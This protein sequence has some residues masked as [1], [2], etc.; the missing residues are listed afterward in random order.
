MKTYI[1]CFEISDIAN[2]TK[3]IDAMVLTKNFCPINDTTW[4][5]RSNKNASEILAEFT[6][7]VAPT[8]RLFVL[9]SGTEASWFNSYGVKHDAW[10]KESL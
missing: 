10:L 2:K 5:I 1:I 7:L 9:R 3:L 4:S 6:P 8:D